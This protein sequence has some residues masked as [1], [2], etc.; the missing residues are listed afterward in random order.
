VSTAEK[1]QAFVLPTGQ[2]LA[3]SKIFSLS[4]ASGESIQV[5]I[6]VEQIRKMTK[7]E[8]APETG[9]DKAVSTIRTMLRDKKETRD[10]QS[11]NYKAS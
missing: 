6:D 5:P 8:V 2:K 4:V 10:W 11:H 7:L 1:S 3:T 9:A